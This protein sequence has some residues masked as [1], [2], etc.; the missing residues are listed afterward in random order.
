[1]AHTTEIV[2]VKHLSGDRLAENLTLYLGWGRYES[3]IN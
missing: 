1:M 3:E 2:L